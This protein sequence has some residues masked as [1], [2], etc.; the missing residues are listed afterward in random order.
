MDFQLNIK[1]DSIEQVTPFE[2]L[3]VAPATSV[4]EVFWLLKNRNTGSV[5]I[6]SD[7]ELLG[8]F[9]ERDPLKLMPEGVDLDG[10]IEEVMTANPVTLSQQDSVGKAITKMSLGGYRRLPIVDEAGR[11]VGIVKASGILNYL[12]GHF[13]QTIYNLPPA[14]HHAT[15]Q[16]EGA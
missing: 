7:A 3:C 10:P 13:P 4:R 5:L 16:R 12:V 8:I 11:P 2:P 6:G 14:P 9:T 15:Q 1:T